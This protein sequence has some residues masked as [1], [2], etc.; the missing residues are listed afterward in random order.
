MEKRFV[1]NSFLI[2][3]VILILSLFLIIVSSNALA[4]IADHVVISEFLVDSSGL[5]SA[6]EFIELYNPTNQDIDI[7]NWDIAYESTTFSS[8]TP[9][10]TIPA[11]S[12]I[13]AHGYFLIGGSSVEPNPDL[14]DGSLGF[15]SSGGH[16]AVRNAGNDVIDMVGY[17]TA[18]SPEGNATS[19]PPT[20]NSSER[21]SS[22]THNENEGN[23]W[24]TNNNSADFT[25]RTTP[26]PQ[27]S[28][29]STEH[30]TEK[31]VCNDA[32]L[33]DF[34]KIQS[35]INA[36]SSGDIITVS[37][38]TYD[39]ESFP[40]VINVPN[41]I[42]KST[43]TATTTI[44]NA[45]ASNYG[46]INITADNVTIGGSG[47]TIYGGGNGT[48]TNY[49]FHHVIDINAD[50][51]TIQD[52]TIIG[53]NGN[54]A[55][56]HIAHD[57][58]TG[59]MIKNNTLR[60]RTAG[61]GWGIFAE[62]LTKAS[63]ED[64]LCYGDNQNWGSGEGA[65]GTCIIVN[66]ADT[67]TIKDNT[68][69]DV[70]YSWLTFIAQYPRMDSTGYMYE[71]CRDSNIT[72]TAVENNTIYNIN[73]SGSKA[74]NFKPCSKGGQPGGWTDRAN[75]TINTNVTVGNNNFY[76]N[77]YAIKI[78]EISSRG[79]TV[80]GAD[81]LKIN[82]NNIYSN[83]DYGAWNGQSET[84]NA[85][86]NYWGTAIGP[87]GAGSGSGNNVSSN[88]LYYPWYADSALTTLSDA[89]T[90]HTSIIE[91]KTI[92]NLTQ[93]NYQT[94][95]N[96]TLNNSGSGSA[97]MYDAYIKTDSFQSDFASSSP[98]Q[99]CGTITA[100][101]SCTKTFDITINGGT[102]SNT[103]YINW[104]F[105]WTNNDGSK[106]EPIDSSTITI[107]DNPVIT[108]TDNITNTISH[109]TNSTS[110]TTI[111]S[112]GNKE[113][114]NVAISYTAGNLLSNWIT[115]SPASISSIAAGSNASLNITVVIPKGT[116][117]G[118]Y[119]GNITIA[120]D[121]AA[122]KKILLEVTVPTDD[123]WYSYPNEIGTFR[124]TNAAGTIGTVYINNTGNIQQT[125]TISYAGDIYDVYYSGL[126]DSSNPT[127]IVV[128]KQTTNS[129]DVKHKGYWQTGSYDLNVTIEVDSATNKTIMNLTLENNNPNINIT[130]PL[131]NSY[132]T[133][134][135]EFNVSASDLNLSNIEFYI[136]NNLVF[137]DTEI[138]YTYNWDTLAYSDDIYTLKAIAY[139][140]AGNYNFSEINVT[141]NNTDD[142]PIL[143]ANIPTIIWNEDS[144]TNLTLSSYFKTIDGDS[145]KYNFSSVNNITV[146]VNNNTQI[147]NF[148]PDTDFFGTRYIIFYAT[149][150]S[151]NVTPSNNITLTITNINDAPSA[152]TLLLPVNT[153]TVF[154]ATG[155]VTLNW[156][157]STDADN[158]V[159]TYYVF[160]GNNT[161]VTSSTTTQN[162]YLPLSGLNNATTYYW[163][164]Y[165]NDGTNNS[166]NSS[167]FQFTVTFDDAPIIT[168]FTPTDL[169]PTVAENSTLVFTIN[170]SDP[171]GGLLN[172]SWY[173]DNIIEKTDGNNF[174]YAPNFTASGTHAIIANI[175]D[176]N[177]NSI[178]NTWTV[179][180]TNTNRAPVLDTISSP[181]TIAE[182]S[183]LTF[184][185]TA[186]DADDNN[187]TYSS[188]SSLTI[189]KINDSIA[190]VSWTPTNDYVGNNTINFTVSDST[191]Q[192][193][194]LVTITVANTNDAPVL[195]SI[196]SLTADQGTLFY[197]D[198]NATDV[199]SGDVLTFSDNS[200]LFTINPSSG[201][202]S[203]TPTNAQVGIY[204]INIT[205]NDS[206]NTQDSEII[207]LTV[208][209]INDAPVLDTI[210]SKTATEDS[211]LTF[212]I[213]AS[214]QDND[215]LTFT[216]NI[217]S[218][219]FTNV[220]NNSLTTVSW[221]PTNEHVGSNTANITVSDGSLT[222]SQLVT[223]AVTNT[224]DAPTISSY[225][226][227]N[228]NPT[229]AESTG[230]QTFN[231][232]ASDVDAGDTLSYAWYRNGSSVSTSNSYAA[233]SLSTGVYNVT[234]IVSDSSSATARQSWTLN[235]TTSIVS[236]KYSGTITSHTTNEENA[237]GVTVEIANGTISFTVSINLSNAGNIDD[238]IEIRQGVI[239]IDTGILAGLNRRASTT[240]KN[241]DYTKTPLIY[242]HPNF[243]VVT[244]GSICPN[245]TCTNINY[246]P[247]T[248]ILTFDV[249][250]FSTYYT[251][252][253]TTNGAPVITSTP[254]TNAIAREIY[255]YNVDATD[256][257]GDTLTYSLTTAPTGMSIS[258]SSGLITWTPEE[259]QVGM[260]NVSVQVSDNNL[261]DS[262]SFNISV[263]AAK[264][265]R[266]KDLDVKVDGRTDK[267]LA[268]GNTIKREAKPESN[269]EF[270][271]EIE[272]GF[273]DEEDL[274]LEDIIVEI[275]IKDIDDG[276][277]ID[278]ESKEFDLRAEKDKKVTLNFK[279]PL[280]VD[281]DTYDVNIHVEAEDENGTEHEIDW[282]LYLEVEKEKHDIRIIKA[283]LN[284]GVVKCEKTT[285]LNTEL[286]N[287]GTDEEDEVALEITSPELEFNFRKEDIELEEGTDD[288]RYSRTLN[289]AIPDKLAVGTY[290]IEINAYYDTIKL[291]DTET[292]NLEV[293]ECKKIIKE[294]EKVK[295]EP[296][297]VI[298]E[299]KP[300]VEPKEE[301]TKIT[302]RESP[303][304]IALLATALVVLTGVVVFA[305]GAAIM[306]L[307][308]K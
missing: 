110:S 289:I 139:D 36:S 35:A 27:N 137:N 97:P 282:I 273:T 297:V 121:S 108:V 93:D 224:N 102:I 304:Y 302:F 265:L 246:N 84:V 119:T 113:L 37:A 80:L 66:D 252:T 275:T 41:L 59:H 156:S 169:T 235:S 55:G 150:S 11:S 162:T 291:S 44:I 199:D 120:D 170:A 82:Y 160:Y 204:K 165:A 196:G 288:N 153:S 171:D 299:T 19:A 129:F 101:S 232:T 250:G 5:E 253:N 68:A 24:D 95:I 48:A 190:T 277:D 123:S 28:S 81:N 183:T 99:S 180:V 146:N 58:G 287:L 143:I 92:S 227:T 248:G 285:T 76:N 67:L 4:T 187:L 140:T 85:T 114:S 18:D 219:S 207:T 308:R 16:I 32:L 212:N 20:D 10:A 254:A 231:V 158:D 303:A 52:N 159:L 274:K 98:A 122:S 125:Y 136:N 47:F 223:I 243:N 279:V 26:Q 33:C 135:V 260:H 295:A 74:I 13:S 213:T 266:I 268:D 233:S 56:I 148:T 62:N 88:V 256:P 276:D 45:S 257:D 42:I 220:A 193:S 144:I 7:S 34:T 61:E 31:T 107:T 21:K 292:V 54:T 301:V 307:R 145:L 166:A 100:G 12:T 109:G 261:T 222:D 124:K 60:H 217:S 83:D 283:N 105:N 132:P 116:S 280:E 134:L 249:T 127:S 168:N 155:K 112:T 269:I 255:N 167:M 293:Q 157:E 22:L 194:Q 78:D 49:Q 228:F 173:L 236:S 118:N 15:A 30:K 221:T 130:N 284:P 96:V 263:A 65:P 225:S 298:D 40:I 164:V 126:W 206:S 210:S 9:V 216:S 70:K 43:G 17:G 75:F 188:N 138:N 25:T 247:S 211:Q 63:I 87:G 290:P 176:N 185:I 111:N 46:A 244:G 258:S 195:T 163:R 272:N 237:T 23:G 29:N 294:E 296:V 1:K 131:N 106:R 239:A 240:M 234:V 209:N 6:Y 152:P 115:F 149:D 72:N 64:N 306:L 198:V 51:A 267:N 241:L 8:W 175:T 69:Y 2:L 39:N 202:F 203:F 281:E 245:T 117:P 147:A 151:N 200:T 161:N 177:S 286:I 179:T 91:T 141:V 259:S 14:V 38:G 71:D 208:S 238:Y 192:D 201:E 305:L 182:D 178:A 189:S 181:K 86:L 3:I 53:Y 57:K 104:R 172:Y 270:K 142:A 186:S 262:Q 300:K 264:K 79:S 73:R 90:T 215:A 133:G 128:S 251:Q 103:Y 226:P 94:Q 242:Y 230:T 154:S 77:S 229:I 174:T 50:Y 218:I 184:N 197:Y 205:I 89:T 271:I 214:D 278:E 191:S